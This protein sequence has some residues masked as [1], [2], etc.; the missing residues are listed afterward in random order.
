MED[1]ATLTCNERSSGV[2]VTAELDGRVDQGEFAS[3]LSVRAEDSRQMRLL[4]SK[5]LMRHPNTSEPNALLLE[6]RL[7]LLEGEFPDRSLH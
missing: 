5:E 7:E 1:K 4:V 2:V 6:E 3:I